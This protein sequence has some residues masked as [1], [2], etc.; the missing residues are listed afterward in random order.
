MNGAEWLTE[1]APAVAGSPSPVANSPPAVSTSRGDEWLTEPATAQV[2]PGSAQVSPSLGWRDVPGALTSGI[3]HG[4]GSVGQ[5]LHL[6]HAGDTH[7]AASPFEWSDIWH[8]GSA[9]AKTAYRL[10]EGSPTLA[11]GI[12]GGVAGTALTGGP[13]GGIAGGALGAAG[14]NALQTLGPAFEREMQAS[15]K[16]PDG[17]WSR[18][19]KST[20]LSGAATGAAWAAFPARFFE[21]PLK[22]AAFQIF[23]VQP[24]LAVA[25][26]AG[27]NILHDRPALEGAGEAYKEGAI[28]TAVP[29]AGRAAISRIGEATGLTHPSPQQMAIQAA[30]KAAKGEPPTAAEL[31]AIASRHYQDIERANIRYTNHAEL[32]AL[33]TRMTDMLY[34]AGADPR[35]EGRVF[36]AVDSL[37]QSRRPG[38]VLDWTDV[39]HARKM[40]NNAMADR[41]PATRRAAALAIH[42]ANGLDAWIENPRAQIAA[43]VDPALAPDLARKAALA[44]S[45]WQAGKAM[46]AFDRIVEKADNSSNARE[47]TFRNEIRKIVNNPRAHWQYPPEAIELMRD[48]LQRGFWQAAA[49]ASKLFDPHSSFGLF[50]N[51]MSH[52]MFGPQGLL[53]MPLAMGLRAMGRAPLQRVETQVP[54]MIAARPAGG[55]PQRPTMAER[56]SAYHTPYVGP[57]VYEP[58][59][60]GGAVTE[61]LRAARRADGGGVDQNEENDA[62]KAVKPNDWSDLAVSTP[63]DQQRAP[64]PQMHVPLSTPQGTIFNPPAPE[65]GPPPSTWLDT[66]GGEATALQ[67][68][69]RRAQQSAAGMTQAGWENITSNRPASGAGQMALGMAG[70]LASPFNALIE[71]YVERPAAAIGGEDFGR[72][73]GLVAGLPFGGG[74]VSAAKM[75]GKIAE[76]PELGMFFAPGFKRAQRVQDLENAGWS[77]ESIWHDT[78]A[79]RDAQGNLRYEELG[80]SRLLFDPRSVKK[81][82][83]VTMP[84]GQVVDAPHVYRNAPDLADMEV[85]MQHRPRSPNRGE[86]QPYSRMPPDAAAMQ[87]GSLGPIIIKPYIW[88]SPTNFD[89]IKNLFHEGQHALDQPAGYLG[90]ASKPL[91]WSNDKIAGIAEESPVWKVYQ[92]E[93]LKHGD[94][95]A[96]REAA[97][98]HNYFG[99]V[100]EVMARLAD[101]R[102]DRYNFLRELD[103]ES[104]AQAYARQYPWREE[105][106]PRELQHWNT[107]L[108]KRHGGR[109]GKALGIAK[110]SGRT[111]IP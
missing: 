18:A 38:S 16:D 82:E 3:R 42:G 110:Q 46:E 47:V 76:H 91:R 2:S 94:E 19:V 109:I 49:H 40:L 51:F 29:I 14:M 31:S 68:A 59:A 103:S 95:A 8:P 98:H 30:Q 71:Q 57:L 86:Y 41:D 88:T 66:L 58:R 43:G 22:N 75:A 73:A 1:P 56:T 105:D 106:V 20:L 100:D 77:R 85:V 36:A 11:G 93:L 26:Q 28:G 48:G 67:D 90:H 32:D 9:V 62:S 101:R 17:A 79:F 63:F 13:W 53:A 80:P 84:Y 78:N 87:R 39:E 97:R 108:P 69:Y 10:G 60:A 99:Q 37:T 25:H 96:A 52:S 5:T 74:E 23:G 107:P 33:N 21:G 54:R 92:Q 24:G 61:A 89:P 45:Y 7:A 4:I 65:P 27:E 72:R 102:E 50:T 111:Y 83:E 35:T 44:R 6:G 104:A 64:P 81:G 70:A 15:P 12:S 34:K 55:M